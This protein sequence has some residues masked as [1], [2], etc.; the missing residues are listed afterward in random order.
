MK[1]V[2]FWDGKGFV[3]VS[4]IHQ[5][6]EALNSLGLN[7]VKAV[8][9]PIIIGFNHYSG[10]YT[11]MIIHINFF[12]KEGTEIGYFTPIMRT[13]FILDKPRQWSDYFLNLAEP[14][15]LPE[16]PDQVPDQVIIT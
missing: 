3:E 7:P 13:V 10:C 4:N 8:H 16:V 9:I 14:V 15:E 1:Q 2:E 6:M 11:K 12:N 5:A